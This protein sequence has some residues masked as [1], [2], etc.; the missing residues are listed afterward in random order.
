[1]QMTESGANA[2]RRATRP[3]RHPLRIVARGKGHQ[4]G[5][6]AVNIFDDLFGELTTQLRETAAHCPASAQRLKERIL[7]C[8]AA[9]ERA[10]AKIIPGM[11]RQ[12]QVER[13]LRNVSLALAKAKAELAS[14]QTHEKEARHLAMHDALT[15]LPN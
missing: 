2:T 8:A 14:M 5:P 15:A 11:V 7:N 1:M 12:L 9:L 4:A 13:A 3:G 10:H 6:P